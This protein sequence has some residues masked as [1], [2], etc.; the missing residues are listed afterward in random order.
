MGLSIAGIGYESTLFL[1]KELERSG[2]QTCLLAI[3]LLALVVSAAAA[4]WCV[5][6]RL[7]NFRTTAEVARKREDGETATELQP[8]RTKSNELGEFIWTLFWWQIWSFALGILFLVV[9]VAGAFS[10]AV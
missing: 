1:N 9:V 2:W 6:S 7:R 8:L 10:S 4:I 5:I 3:S